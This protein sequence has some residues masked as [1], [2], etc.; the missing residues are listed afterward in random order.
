M[1]A[2]YNSAAIGWFS[3]TTAQNG[4]SFGERFPELRRKAIAMND[5]PCSAN[6]GSCQGVVLTILRKYFYRGFPHPQRRINPPTN[7]Q[8]RLVHTLGK[9][10]TVQFTASAGVAVIA[11]I[12][13]CNYRA[14]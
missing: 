2:T 6:E 7:D 8:S 5:H 13:E 3:S 4:V 14:A 11:I 10:G 9:R 12:A 1:G